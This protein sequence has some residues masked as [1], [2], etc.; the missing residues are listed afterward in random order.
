MTG[1]LF[2]KGALVHVQPVKKILIPGKWH[3]AE[4]G[5]QYKDASYHKIVFRDVVRTWTS[6]DLTM[7]QS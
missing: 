6:E 1:V 7:P 2:R 4:S 5:E 3:T